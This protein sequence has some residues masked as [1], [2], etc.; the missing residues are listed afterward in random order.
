MDSS[1]LMNQIQA[2]GV[3]LGKTP[4]GIA[5]ATRALHPAHAVIG[6]EGIPD[7][8]CL[9]SC[10]LEF[11]QNWTQSAP[12]GTTNSWSYLFVAI[13]SPIMLTASTVTNDATTP[14]TTDYYWYNNQ[15]SGSGA[16][17]K[18][19]T[20][21]QA[22]NAARLVYY[23][24]TLFMDA[25]AL[26]DQ[27]TMCG[28]QVQQTWKVTYNLTTPTAAYNGPALGYDNLINLPGA[29]QWV[30]REGAYVPIKLSSSNQYIQ[31]ST[32]Y[33][34]SGLTSP[35][36]AQT[37]P[38]ILDGMLGVL[39]FKN[40]SVNTS[41]RVTLRMGVEVQVPPSSPYSPFTRV[42]LM[43]DSDAIT[44]YFTIASRLT[45]VY[46]ASY[47][48]WG[49]LWGVIKKVAGSVLRGAV[50]SIPIVGPALD[51]AITIYR[52]P[53]TGSRTITNASST[54]MKSTSVPRPP[55][56]M[57]ARERAVRRRIA[58]KAKPNGRRVTRT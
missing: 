56:S 14:V 9:P 24:V 29:V 21:L 16:V 46:P 20:W 51:E 31:Q 18:S 57:P 27:G 26:S 49:K 12:A 23:G 7:N 22:V 50:R 13:P 39:S 58:R 5:F 55:A 36:T 11:R 4:H 41:I 10:M 2:M 53:A 25:P 37:I 28:A 48:D 33:S 1:K 15:I 52:E 3:S 54:P 45:D 35:T 30:A 32:V 43:P 19:T 40:L 44:S 47:N 8:T 42:P 6:C 34:Y 17:G 38:Q